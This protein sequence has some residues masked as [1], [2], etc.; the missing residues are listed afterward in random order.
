MNLQSLKTPALV[1]DHERLKR[2]AER[3]SQRVKSLNVALRPHVKTHKC[4]EVARLQTE[5][6]S[7]AVTVSTLAEAR[8]F[9]AAGFRD[10]TYAVPIEPGKFSEAI[11]LTK[12]RERFSL[13]TDDL[14]AATQLNDAAR[15]AG[16]TLELFLKVDCGYHRCG[17]EPASDAALAIPRF[18]KGASNLRF[19]GILTHAGHS[20]HARSTD[21]LLAIARHERD[22]MTEYADA[23]RVDGAPPPV[24]SIGSTP[25]ITH[26]DHLAGIDE[27]RPGN[28]IFF[29]AFQATLGSCAFT[30]C[31]LTVLAA[32]THLDRSRRKII[33]D[34]GAVALSKDRG[35]VE[36]DKSCGYGRVLDLEGNELGLRVNALSQEHG[37]IVME[38]DALLDKLKVGTRLRVL[39]NHSCLT[40]AQHSHYN[41][42]QGERLVD[43]WEIQRGW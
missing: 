16:V 29:D 39:A 13:L 35:A 1:L 4:V 10:I 3:M 11:E 42:L 26:V 18:I 24:V 30:D 22:S 37:E 36:L 19:A 2:N 27:A 15:R 17:V 6:Q 41:V 31:A 33:I 40:A 21:E 12:A 32:I 38:D 8:A 25:T 14:E 9:A 28:Y 7:G 23:L 5:G 34:A 20:Y 43:R